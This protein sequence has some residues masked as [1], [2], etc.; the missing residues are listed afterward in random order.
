PLSGPAH[1]RGGPTGRALRRREP[2]GGAQAPRGTRFR[3]H[4]VLLT[5]AGHAS[6]AAAVDRRCETPCY[7]A[8]ENAA[9]TSEIGDWGARPG[10]CLA[11]GRMRVA[12]RAPS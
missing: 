4:S 8:G 9:R 1:A 3:V 6:L 7:G 5:P 10:R 12:R 11:A 2:R